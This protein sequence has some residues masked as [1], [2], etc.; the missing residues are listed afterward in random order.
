MFEQNNATCE[1]RAVIF[2]R[3]LWIVCSAIFVDSLLRLFSGFHAFF[4]SPLAL[5]EAG[6]WGGG[7]GAV[8]DCRVGGGGGQKK[9][10]GS[11]YPPGFSHKK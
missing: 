7:G 6:A 3:G 11:G 9:P 1:H 10:C 4:F 5:F 2:Q 8:R